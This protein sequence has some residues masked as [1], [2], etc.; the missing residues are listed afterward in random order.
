[1]DT[2]ESGGILFLFTSHFVQQL[3]SHYYSKGVLDCN[4]QLLA[5]DKVHPLQTS[6][7]SIACHHCIHINPFSFL[8]N[9]KLKIGFLAR[10]LKPSHTT[11]RPMELPSLK[12]S[13]IIT[14]K[15]SH[16]LHYGKDRKIF[17]DYCNKNAPGKLSYKTTI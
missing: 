17:Q 8:N 12:V 14:N 16:G 9:T 13:H 11:P 6:H 4:G 15:V 3:K 2:L 1:M 10:A 7:I 5:V